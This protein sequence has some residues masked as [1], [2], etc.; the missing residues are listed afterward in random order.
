MVNKIAKTEKIDFSKAKKDD[1]VLIANKISEK[2][3]QIEAL[4][5][6]ELANKLKDIYIS[7]NTQENSNLLTVF[8]DSINVEIMTSIIKTWSSNNDD[9]DFYYEWSE[10][11]PEVYIFTKVLEIKDEL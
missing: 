6:S 8:L 1:L 4:A 7:K 2:T 10:S 9:M 11:V 3:Q 5:A